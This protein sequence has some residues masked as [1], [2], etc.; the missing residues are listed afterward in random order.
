M[1]TDCDVL[2]IGAGITGL[3]VAFQLRQR[4]FR[5]ELIE[6][7]SRA[8]GVIET[9]RAGGVLYER[10]PNSVLDTTA[11]IDALLREVG[12]SGERIEMN[13]ACSRR[14]VVRNG[15]TV[16]VPTSP[17][18]FLRTPLF[19]LAAKLRVLRE[20][21]IRRSAP[22]VDESV[23]RFVTRRL[24]A[25]FL[26]YAIE[27]FV[28]GVYAGSPE[29]LSLA[30]AF[31]RL[32]ALEQRYGS[33]LKGQVLGAR[34][35]SQEG[36]RSRHSARSF[37]FKRGLQTLT[38]AL[39]RAGPHVRL[40]TRA[41]AIRP[42]GNGVIEADWVHAGALASSSAH[43]VVLA[44]PAHAGAT[45]VRPL[46]PDAA[47]ALDAI[48]YAPV[49]SV[50]C[51]Y[52]RTGIAHAL[53]GFG[54]LSPRVERRRILG[55]LF[56]STLFEGRAPAGTVLLT[57]FV[58]GRRDPACAL[59]SEGEIARIVQNELASLL[60]VRCAAT[61]TAVTRWERAIPQ[62]TIGHRDRIHRAEHAERT[63]PGLFLSGSYRGGVSVGECIKSAHETAEA[64]E[65]HVLATSRSLTRLAASR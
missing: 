46:C 5:V 24:G 58:G 50:A 17:A 10:G 63:V 26:D 25:E 35:R 16:A 32:H 6:A 22:D 34:E 59:Q 48:P 51:S 28:A 40:A 54:F 4:G 45:L 38:D 27:P 47:A 43:A 33:L 19:S 9:V 65:Q 15:K 31:P 57:T 11:L 18:A 30:A 20:P 7:A 2:V 52:P 14:Y 60:G 1:T 53:D 21:F 3:T 62:Y 44:I 36:E 37:S 41:T 39:A 42:R 12:V 8:G 61:H 29:E 56:S 13:P 64:V 55:S 23:A 49:A